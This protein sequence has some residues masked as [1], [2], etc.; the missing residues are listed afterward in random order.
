[1]GQILERLNKFL[2]EAGVGSRRQCDDLI[3]M[4]RVTVD[5]DIV[6]QLGTQ[7]DPETQKITFDGVAVQVEKKVYWWLNKP[8]GV[9]CTNRDPHGRPT[10]L[11][12][13]PNI[14]KRIYSVGRLDED[15]TGLLLLTNDGTLADKLTHPKYG[16]P[17]TYQVLVAGRVSVDDCEKMKRGV[18]LSD[19]PARA[20]DVHRIGSQGDATKLEVVLCEGHNREIRRMFARLGHKV[21]H[22]ERVAIG[23]IKIRKMRMGEARA[24]TV[25][26]VNM[27]R[28]LAAAAPKR[29]GASRVSDNR[30]DGGR[31]TARRRAG[32]APDAGPS[33]TK[34]HRDGEEARSGTGASRGKKIARGGRPGAAKAGGRPGKGLGKSPSKGFGKGTGAGPSKGKGTGKGPGKRKGTGTASAKGLGGRPKKGGNASFAKKGTRK[35]ARPGKRIPR[36]R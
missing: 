9:L 27:L 33:K 31:K 26:E 1:M 23:P 11:D 2:A 15:S 16:V 3:K 4:G 12:L 13:V 5:G 24:A 17:K 28:E 32:H 21:M 34:G 35:G 6:T 20:K 8:K 29:R 10:V 14:G 22:L 19:G 30:L 18:W 7:I 25:D 36:G